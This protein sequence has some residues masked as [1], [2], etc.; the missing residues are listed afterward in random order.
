MFTEINNIKKS[1]NQLS[2][3]WKSNIQVDMKILNTVIDIKEK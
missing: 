2:Q 1:S 3:K